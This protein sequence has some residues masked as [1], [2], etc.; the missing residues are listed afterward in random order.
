[1]ERESGLNTIAG[2]HKSLH[3]QKKKTI[4]ILINLFIFPPTIFK[5]F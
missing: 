2:L 4:Q 3:L 5:G 1:M